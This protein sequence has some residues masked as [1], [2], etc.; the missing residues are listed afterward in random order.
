MNARVHW[1]EVPRPHRQGDVAAVGNL[2]FLEII[3]DARHWRQPQTYRQE[4]DDLLPRPAPCHT[5]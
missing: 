2:Q 4:W 5:A 3:V 1:I